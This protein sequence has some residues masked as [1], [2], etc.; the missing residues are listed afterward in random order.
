MKK[1][2]RLDKKLAE[3]SEMSRARIQKMI[4]NGL[5]LVNEKVVT[6]PHFFVSETDIIRLER[7]ERMERRERPVADIKIIYED[8]DAIIFEKP[9]GLM[10]HDAP[11]KTE[12]TVVDALIKHYPKIKKIGD[13]STRP[14]I[15]HRLDKLA[16]GIMIAAKNQ[17]AFEFLKK[18]FSE[19]R[20]KKEYLVLVY[21][22]P[23]QNTG[24]A[25]FKLARSKTKGRMMAKPE[26]SEDGR[27]AVTHYE[28][29]KKL[30]TTTLLRV[31]IETG[32]THQIRAHM[33]ALNLPVVGDPLYKKTR[34]KN[35]RPSPLSRL[36]LHAHKLIITLPN[37][38][39]KTFVS[40]LPNELEEI[41]KL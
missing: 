14:G 10:V 31:H 3:Q 36:F 9:A 24:T 30:R 35:I 29:V 38:E 2:K 21:G 40:P 16:S 11:G 15:V 32:R 28:V 5:V 20:V 26:T 37:R 6:T 17:N 39:T 8:D 1:T 25:S 13:D 33:R 12:P 4:K 23:S 41:L 7:P 22:T 19:R 27:E 18:Q 34:M